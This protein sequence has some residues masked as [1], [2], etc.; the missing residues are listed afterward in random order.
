MRTVE[1]HRNRNIPLGHLPL[2]ERQYNV[3]T[4]EWRDDPY[5]GKH[6]L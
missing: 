6:P 2:R 1:L 4:A 5:D 3:T